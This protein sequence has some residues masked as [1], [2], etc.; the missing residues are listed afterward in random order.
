[1][2]PGSTTAG[3][4]LLAPL[5]YNDFQVNTFPGGLA[6]RSGIQVQNVGSGVTYV[7][8]T[9]KGTT[10]TGTWTV[11]KSIQPS[12]SE[13]FFLPSESA[14]QKDMYGS[15]VIESCADATCTTPGNGEDIVGIV[16]TTKYG[17]DV[18][19]AYNAF[20]DGSATSKISVPLVYGTFQQSR[21]GAGAE[22]RSGI[23]VMNVDSADT[24]VKVT[25]TNANTAL[26]GGPW[27]STSG[28]VKPGE[29]TTFYLPTVS[30]LPIEFYGSAEIEAVNASGAPVDADI[31]AIVNTTKYVGNFATC[32]PGINHD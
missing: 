8:L 11:T 15:A 4:K 5:V 13:T 27:S 10:P 2:L 18:G 6:W 29:S 31:I 28:A 14:V 30:G 16:N 20:V 22:W 12:A 1:V 24:Y 3:T 26:S 25:F 32:Y 23:Q 19:M 17:A 21:F 9:I 7:R